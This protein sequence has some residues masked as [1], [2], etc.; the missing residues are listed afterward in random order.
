MHPFQPFEL[1]DIDGEFREKLEA[2]LGGAVVKTDRSRYDFWTT[3]CN[4]EFIFEPLTFV[5]AR[6]DPE[7]I[8]AWFTDKEGRT[9]PYI[10]RLSKDDTGPEWNGYPRG[11]PR[12]IPWLLCQT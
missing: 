6:T 10:L 5:I 9:S 12:D 4:F 7:T 2:T 11:D 1:P 8:K 3:E